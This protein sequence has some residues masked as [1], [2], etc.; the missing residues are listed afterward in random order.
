[1]SL[2]LLELPHE[3]LLLL[4]EYLDPGSLDMLSQSCTTLRRLFDDN[5]SW[6]AVSRNARIGR[7]DRSRSRSRSRSVRRDVPA[8]DTFQTIGRRAASEERGRGRKGPISWKTEEV[9]DVVE[10]IDEEMGHMAVDGEQEVEH[11]DEAGDIVRP[12]EGWCSAFCAFCTQFLNVALSFTQKFQ[13]KKSLSQS[14]PHASRGRASS[15]AC[16]L[17]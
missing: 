6:R 2:G 17:V 3:L 10:D 1:M 11:A 13:F 16:T 14:Q 12:L 8:R 7:P 5:L 9:A 4:P 15:T